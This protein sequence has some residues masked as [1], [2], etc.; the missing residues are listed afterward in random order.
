MLQQQLGPSSLVAILGIAALIP[1]NGWLVTMS[2]RRLKDALAFS[3][4]RTKMEGELVSGGSHGEL[5]LKPHVTHQAMLFPFKRHNDLV[6]DLDPADNY[7]QCP[8]FCLSY[9]NVQTG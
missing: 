5:R 2:S 4:D 9:Q 8:H 1:I 7:P 6:T 3:D